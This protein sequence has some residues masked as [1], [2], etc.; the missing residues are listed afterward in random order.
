MLKQYKDPESILQFM[1]IQF[2]SCVDTKG[3]G[4]RHWLRP[5][6]QGIMIIQK[7]RR[8]GLACGMQIAAVWY[9]VWRLARPSEH[10]RTTRLDV[11]TF[12]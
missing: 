5:V 11:E 7:P 9:V 12:Y 3:E 6:R 8:H 4:R 10:I 2:H 1:I